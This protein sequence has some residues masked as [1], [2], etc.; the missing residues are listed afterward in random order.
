M[1]GDT[2]T[3]RK[4]EELVPDDEVFLVGNMTGEAVVLHRKCVTTLLG[5]RVSR[6]FA[7]RTVQRRRKRAQREG[8]R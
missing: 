4:C 5:T 2:W 3:C 8:Y 7:E 6:A 1:R